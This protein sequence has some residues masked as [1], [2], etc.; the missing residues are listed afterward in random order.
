MIWTQF[1]FLFE[2][3][4]IGEILNFVNRNLKHTLF[5]YR[6][7]R[8]LNQTPSKWWYLWLKEFC[9]KTTLAATSEVNFWKIKNKFQKIENKCRK[10]NILDL[11]FRFVRW[12]GRL[13]RFNEAPTSRLVKT[14]GWLAKWCQW[15]LL[16]WV[17]LTW[18][19]LTSFLAFTV[20]ILLSR[21]R[22]KIQTKFFW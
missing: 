16:P 14:F 12:Y 17:Y 18:N 15:W 22:A 2:F 4:I 8:R 6:S 13:P 10:I 5:T 3:C 7:W 11:F 1:D 19:I 9:R 21:Q 20:F